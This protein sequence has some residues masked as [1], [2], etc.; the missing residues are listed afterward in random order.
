[1]RASMRGSMRSVIVTDSALSVG[2]ATAVSINRKSGLFSAQKPASASSLSKIGISSH[3]AIARMLLIRE[4][5]FQT[6]LAVNRVAPGAGSVLTFFANTNRKKCR[7]DPDA[8]AQSPFTSGKHLIELPLIEETLFGLKRS[9]MDDSDLL[10]VGPIHTENTSAASGHPQVKKPGLDRKSR[11]IRQYPHRKRIFER[12]FDLL[13]RQRT[14]EIEGRI[15]PIKLHTIGWNVFSTPMQ[16]LYFVFTWWRRHCQQIILSFF[17]R[18]QV[19]A[20]NPKSQTP[21]PKKIPNPKLFLVNPPS[22]ASVAEC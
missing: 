11:R 6:S 10:P 9:G 18:M 13:Q 20:R 3:L 14:I 7:T 4:R 21:N 1:M 5:Q 17:C 2:P 22:L 15:I 12:F 16:C 19:R 8:L